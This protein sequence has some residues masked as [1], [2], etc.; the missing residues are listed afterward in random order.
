MVEIAEKIVVSDLA[1]SG[2]YAFKSSQIFK[3][4]VLHHDVFISSIFKR[5]I[6]NGETVIASAKH[7][8]NETIVLGAPEEYM[9]ASLTLL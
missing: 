9:N 4:Y 8:E 7:R 2:L 5:M 3:Q 1:T 6:T